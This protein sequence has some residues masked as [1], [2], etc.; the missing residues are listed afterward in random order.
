M[1]TKMTAKAW[2]LACLGTQM[3]NSINQHMLSLRTNTNSNS[4]LDGVPKTSDLTSY[5]YIY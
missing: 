2:V 5:N 1:G 4:I 3:L